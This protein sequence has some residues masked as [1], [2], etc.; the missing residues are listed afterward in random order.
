MGLQFA[1]MSV[2]RA[3]GYTFQAMLIS[4][5]SVW[6]VQFP[7]A[8]ILSNHTMLHSSGLWWAFPVSK[9]ATSVIAGLVLA[10]DWKR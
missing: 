1:P 7:T 6:L 10:R 4:L 2:L 9:V 3:A 5:V 8:Y